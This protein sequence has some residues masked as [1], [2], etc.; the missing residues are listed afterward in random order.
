MIKK[1]NTDEYGEIR[2][3]SINGIDIFIYRFL[4]YWLN[5]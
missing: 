1:F 2:F 5:N 3:K 4:T